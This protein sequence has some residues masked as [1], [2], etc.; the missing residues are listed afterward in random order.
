MYPALS[1]NSI[2]AS[3]KLGQMHDS[4]D[5]SLK[6]VCSLRISSSFITIKNTNQGD[7]LFIE[8]NYSHDRVNDK[9]H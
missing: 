2:H 9:F 8:E 6:K 3:P 7:F 5:A 1:E 4:H